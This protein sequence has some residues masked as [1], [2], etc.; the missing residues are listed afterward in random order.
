MLDIYKERLNSINLEIT[1]RCNYSC[2]MC[3]RQN[4]KFKELDMNYIDAHKYIDEL[5]E[6]EFLIKNIYFHWRGEPT[7]S[8]DLVSVIA[9]TR[10]KFVN[11][12]LILFTNGSNLNDKIIDE[13]LQS[14]IST[15]CISID[16]ID[17][18]DYKYIRGGNINRVLKNFITLMN[19]IDSFSGKKPKVIV[20]TVIIDENLGSLKK[21]EDYF[22]AYNVDVNFRM[23][24]NRSEKINKD[25]CYNLG[26]SLYISSSGNVIPCCMDVDEY[27]ILGNLNDNSIGDILNNNMINSILMGTQME[28]EPFDICKK[29]IQQ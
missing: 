2:I 28:I 21:I 4:S 10:I 11:A 25:G 15:I 16:S 13:L 29:C 27:L 18:N 12:N 24:S 6:I 9:Y 8:K 3:Y 26:K 1:N 22:S 23:D 20:N 5:K 17:V 19:K 7:L 14:G